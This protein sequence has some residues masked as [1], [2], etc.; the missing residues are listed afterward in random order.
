M[1]LH[2]RELAELGAGWLTMAAARTAAAPS[3]RA[4]RA[5]LRKTRLKPTIERFATSMR[6]KPCSRL[7][8]TQRLKYVQALRMRPCA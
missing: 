3:S 8:A 2:R 4:D 5:S 6:P 7:R 1:G